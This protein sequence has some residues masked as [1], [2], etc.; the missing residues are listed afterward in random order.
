MNTTSTFSERKRKKLDEMERR[1][2]RNLTLLSYLVIVVIVYN[3]HVF[4][5][6]R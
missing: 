2:T 1:A 5:R 4:D 3:V 6:S